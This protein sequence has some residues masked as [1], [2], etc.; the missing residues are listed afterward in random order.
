M[1]FDLRPKES[2]KDLYDR[3][4][5]YRELS[6]LTGSGH[7]V[8]VLGKRMT[9]KT[10]LI[11]TFARENKGIY[12]NLLGA[13]SFED[14]SKRLLA[15][16]GLKLDELTL[17][18]KFLQ[19]RWGRVLDEAFQFVKEKIIVLDEVQEISSPHFLKI[20]KRVWDEYSGIR[21]VF[22]GSYIGVLRRLLEPS[23]ASPL[24]GRKPATIVLKP[25]DH[26]TS[27]NFLISGFQEYHQ[28]SFKGEEIEEAV[29]RLNGYVGWLTYYGNFR[30]ERRLPHDEALRETVREGSKIIQ[31]ELDHFLKNRR[32]ELY[33]KVLRIV[34]AGARWSE[35]KRDLNINS[36]VLNDI[37][38]N[39]TSAMIV[40]GKE[41]YYWIEDPIMREAVKKLRP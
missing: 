24:Y 30:C 38:K 15:G 8:A 39:L 17:N 40:E 6:R 36:K 3:V 12:V 37:L 22:S 1:L 28:I 29:E 14:V 35:I 7:W 34:R 2:L 32:R 16:L 26:E 13:R 27:K 4:A 11:K 18:L 10:S 5:E 31:T 23:P 19:I 20:L 21:I 41:G 33:V 9:G 25:F